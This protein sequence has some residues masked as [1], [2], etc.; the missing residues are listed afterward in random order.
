MPEQKN[1]R[2]DKKKGAEGGGGR[3]GMIEEYLV[4]DDIPLL[5]GFFTFSQ[6]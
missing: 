1:T 3:E 5:S 2:H 6:C 4:T